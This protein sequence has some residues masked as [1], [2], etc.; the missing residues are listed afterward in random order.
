MS[1]RSWFRHSIQIARTEWTRS[2]RQRGRVSAL[3]AGLVV[4]LVIVSGVGG[5]GA[6]SIG[7]A[8]Y[9][10]LATVSLGSMQVAATVGFLM[11]LWQFAQQTAAQLERINTNLLLTTVPAR[12]I[13]LGVVFFVYSRVAVP[14]SLPLLCV[15]G[16]FAIGTR[17]LV[18]ALS[19]LI[20][21][22]GF[23]ALAVLIGVGL[24][25]AVELATTRSPRIRRYLTQLPV[26]AFVLLVV[27]WTQVIDDGL[28]VEYL[29]RFLGDVPSAWFVD[30]GLLGISG[31]Q[32]DV[33]R[34]KIGRAH[35]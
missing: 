34:G 30:L 15:A 26:V 31:G 5:I 9:S 27:V 22:A 19:I 28:S 10:G 1:S 18:S 23:L 14:L 29:L 7:R 2:R 17:S 6:Y 25:L 32:S 24:S 35:V 3:R 20:A 33:L 12:E 11:L 21:V 8:I 4:V 16:G 13:I